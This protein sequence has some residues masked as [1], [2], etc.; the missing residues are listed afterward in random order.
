[1]RIHTSTEW[2]LLRSVCERVWPENLCSVLHMWKTNVGES[3]DTTKRQQ[4]HSPGQTEA[5]S[6]VTPEPS[7]AEDAVHDYRF[8]LDLWA[9]NCSFDVMYI[10]L[11]LIKQCEPCVIIVSVCVPLLLPSCERSVSRRSMVALPS[12]SFLRVWQHHSFRSRRLWGVTLLWNKTTQNTAHQET[13]LINQ[14]QKPTHNKLTHHCGFLI[15]HVLL[16]VY[17][18][19]YLE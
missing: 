13:G 19:N 11:H 2:T 18:L 9:G 15:L 10:K 7:G 1:M 6:R 4:L 5:P 12:S 17:Q 16:I 3:P 14:Q 8:T